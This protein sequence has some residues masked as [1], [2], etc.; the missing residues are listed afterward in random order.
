MDPEL[1]K[2]IDKNISAILSSTWVPVRGK[3][4]KMPPPREVSEPL[5]KRAKVLPSLCQPPWQ[6]LISVSMKW[7]HRYE[8][9]GP[10]ALNQICLREC[11][12]GGDCLF[13]VVGIG[14]HLWQNPNLTKEAISQNSEQ[15]M[16]EA[17]AWAASGIHANNIDRILKPYQTE[18]FQDFVWRSKVGQRSEYTVW[19]A[20]AETWKPQMWGGTFSYTFPDTASVPEELRQ[21]AVTR[22]FRPPEKARPYLEPNHPQFQMLKKAQE[23]MPVDLDEKEQRD[24]AVRMFKAVSLQKVV[25]T[26]GEK[27]RGDADA[28]EWMTLGQ[29]PVSNKK[30]GFIIISSEGKIV[31]TFYP[32]NTFMEYY[33][34]LYNYH[35]HH[36]QL[37]GI[38]DD[39]SRTPRSVFKATEIPR[40]LQTV[41]VQDCISKK[42]DVLELPPQHP[43]LLQAQQ[44]YP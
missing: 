27:F 23:T 5:S 21:T 13:Y 42:R 11:G 40:V 9:Q 33:M 6:P 10:E 7:R 43:M 8:T 39:K 3:S 32:S 35:H 34:I 37:A 30:L 41:W 22:V 28:L 25:Q 20:F 1:Q 29:N 12:A 24:Y 4:Q 14:Y 2:Q 44:M 18:W 38:A 26:A 15:W 17:R 16:L 31:C 36:W 19:P